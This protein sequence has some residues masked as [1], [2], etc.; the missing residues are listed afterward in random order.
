MVHNQDERIILN[1]SMA[2]RRHETANG[3]IK[4]FGMVKDHF[5]HDISLHG[6]CYR[7]CAVLVQLA[8]VHGK[9][10]FQVPE[11]RDSLAD[12]ARAAARTAPLPPPNDDG[13]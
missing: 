5:R 8:I 1:R 4:M 12:D 10:L 7:A 9:P 11:Y 3:R 2:R 6:M 13:L